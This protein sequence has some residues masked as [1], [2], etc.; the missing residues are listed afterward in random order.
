MNP[1]RRRFRSFAPLCVLA[2]A[3]TVLVAVPGILPAK[4]SPVSTAPPIAL[5]DRTPTLQA[6]VHAR[7]VQGPGRVIEDGTLVVRDGRI[8]AV[9][10]RLTPPRGAAVRDLRGATIY[11]GLIDA[12]LPVGLPSIPWPREVSNAPGEPTGGAG[13]GGAGGLG[14]AGASSWNPLVTPQQRIERDLVADSLSLA[15]RKTLRGQGITAA[16]VS[17]ARGIVK[18]Q[19]AVL[20][21]GDGPIGSLVIKPQAALHLTLATPFNFQNRGYP[22]SPMGALALIRQTFLDADWYGRAQAAAAR[23]ARLPRVESDEGLATLAAWQATTAPLVIDAQDENYALRAHRLGK[24]LGRTT[25]VRGSG[26]EYRAL[27]QIDASGRAFVV[28][29]AFPRAPIVDSPEQSRNVSLEEL[30]HWD[31]A[32]ENPARLARAGVTFALTSDRL[33]DKGTFLA[34]VRKAVERGLSPDAAL[35]ALTTT[36]A[37]LLGVEDRL[38]TL[39]PGRHASFVITDGDLFSKATR[40][41]ETWID[42]EPYPI[43]PWPEVDV[44][45]RWVARFTPAPSGVAANDTLVLVLSGAP[46]SL[47]GT[48]RLGRDTKV[49]SAQVLERRLFVT[50]PG[51]SAGVA[52]LL[53]LSAAVERGVLE[54]EGVWPDGATFAWSARRVAGWVP[55]PDTSRAKPPKVALAEPNFPFGDFGRARVPEQPGLVAFEHATVWTCGPKGRL[56]DATVVVERGKIRS[57]GTGE[58]APAGA[59]VVDARGMHLTPGLIDAHSHSGTDGGINEGGQNTTAEV[60]IGD[61][62]EPADIAI[63]RELAGGLTAAHILH[64]SANAIG[65][66]SQLIKLRWGMADEDLKFEGWPGTIKFALGENPKQSNFPGANGQASTRFPQTRMGVE[67]LIRDKFT[68]AREY[69]AEKRAGKMAGGLPFRKDLE[70]EAIGEILEGR[71][72]IHCHSYRQDE[73][74]MLIRLSEEFGIQV[75]TFQHILEGYKVADAMARHGAGGS[76][77]SDWWAYKM[78]VIDA[79]PYNGALMHNAGVLVSFNSDSDELARRLNTEA[80]KAVKYGGVPEEEALKFVTW[81]PA[82]QLKV[83]SRVGSIEPGK[84]A[85]LALWSGPPLSAYSRCEQ[86]WIDGR[87]YFDRAEDLAMRETQGRLKAA[88]IQRVLEG[89]DG[90]GGGGPGARR[91]PRHDW[92]D[93]HDDGSHGFRTAADEVEALEFGGA[94]ESEARTCAGGHR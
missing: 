11:P 45:G 49:K 23:D 82:R 36:P 87:R 61:F 53:R 19:S 57:V 29:V 76:S 92:A 21:L 70:L 32:P 47:G 15:L 71:R 3:A 8:E 2:G 59:L 6:F 73:I 52:G 7:I 74:L 84:D 93:G 68:A 86:T 16:L 77:F 58:R 60:R 38:G 78:E 88:L 89:D 91:Q 56:E 37:R 51:D 1:S 41:R 72:I 66:Q 46:D 40:V 34:Q 64:G 94:T 43:K 9:G 33:E 65:G 81:N 26:R 24:E 4:A 80:G 62:I 12:S 69:L 54:G 27:E 75:G 90:G 17:P 35:A 13:A 55:P 63:Y 10:R 79:I 42:G 30:M 50:V 83:E 18:G 22:T 44:R 31:L 85:D 20:A 25:I 39:D 14:G 67:Q 28:P 5:R 48:L